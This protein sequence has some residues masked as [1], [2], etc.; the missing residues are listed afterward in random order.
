[1]ETAVP[2]LVPPLKLPAF[3]EIETARLLAVDDHF[4]VVAVIPSKARYW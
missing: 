1:M 4:A 3:G 2:K